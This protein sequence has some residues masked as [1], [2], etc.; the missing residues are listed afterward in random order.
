MIVVRPSAF[1]L[2]LLF[3]ESLRQVEAGLLVL[4]ED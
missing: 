4:L 3:R 1:P 2:F